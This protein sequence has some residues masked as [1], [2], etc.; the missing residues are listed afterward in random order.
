MFISVTGTAEHGY[1]A[2]HPAGNFAAGGRFSISGCGKLV[3]GVAQAFTPGHH[4]GK[5]FP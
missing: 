2:E 5:A 3:S 1:L 4:N